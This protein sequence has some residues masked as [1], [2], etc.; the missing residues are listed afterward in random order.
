MY[1]TLALQAAALAFAVLMTTPAPRPTTEGTARVV[2]TAAPGEPQ[3]LH[4]RFHFG[5][6]PVQTDA[7]RDRDPEF[8][9]GH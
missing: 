5:C 9:H 7:V 1:P 2:R 4:C 6:A 8:V 3:R